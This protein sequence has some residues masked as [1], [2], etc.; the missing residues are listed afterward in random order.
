MVV[1]G[2]GQYLTSA[3]ITSDDMQSVYGVWDS[4]TDEINQDDLVEQDIGFGS[5]TEGV[6][7]QHADKQCRGFYVVLWLVHGSSG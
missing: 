5:T 3:D 6:F 2:T 4:G 7:A 1:F